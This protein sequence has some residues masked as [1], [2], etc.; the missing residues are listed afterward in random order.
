MGMVPTPF[1]HGF[2][3]W[4]EREDVSRKQ[5]HFLYHRTGFLSHEASFSRESIRNH[6]EGA[7]PRPPKLQQAPSSLGPHRV[8]VNLLGSKGPTDHAS[9]SESLVLTD[10]GT[11]SKILTSKMGIKRLTQGIW[12]YTIIYNCGI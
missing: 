2:G 3:I 8:R 10:Q 9:V 5:E 12:N 7:F 6:G 4:L 11:I 1:P